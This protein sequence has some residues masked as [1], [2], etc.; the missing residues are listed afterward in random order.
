ML[1]M[2]LSFCAPPYYQGPVSDHFDGTRF[3]NPGK[4]MDKG[5]LEVLKW[6]WTRKPQPWPA[7]QEL[8][9]TDKPP[10]RVQG[11][12]LRVSLVGHVTVSQAISQ[13]GGL[14]EGARATDV[15]VIR[16]G[17]GNRPLPL[18]VNLQKVYDGTDLQQDIPLKFFDIVYVPRSQIANVNIWVDQYIRR[19]LPISL[20]FFYNFNP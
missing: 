20:A 7:Y 19:N 16:H 18:T 6:Q 5:L 17:V 14:K 8:P 9:A 4:P 2:C 3:F 1:V 11:N 15:V 12:L 10:Q 13:A